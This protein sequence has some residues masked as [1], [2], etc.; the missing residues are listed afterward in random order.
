M[1]FCFLSL[2]FQNSWDSLVS[3]L[4]LSHLRLFFVVSVSGFESRFCC[5]NVGFSG[6]CVVVVGCGDG[7]SVYDAGC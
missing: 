4:Y 6:L 3:C 1:G 2:L 5:T 7:S